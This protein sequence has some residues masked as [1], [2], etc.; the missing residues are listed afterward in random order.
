MILEKRILVAEDDRTTRDAWS[1]L[2][3]AWGYK[4]KTAENGEIA[5]NEIAAYDPHILL[6][7]LNLP[8][9]NAETSVTTEESKSVVQQPVEQE[10]SSSTTTTTQSNH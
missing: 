3:V 6:L 5:L 7:D 8:K 9:K 1:E 10:H 2:I 4:V